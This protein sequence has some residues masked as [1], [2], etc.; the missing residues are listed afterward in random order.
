MGEGGRARACAKTADESGPTEEQG[1]KGE[2]STNR[3]YDAP[4]AALS[5]AEVE[6]LK[7]LLGRLAEVLAP[8]EQSG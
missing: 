6:A 1:E 5:E 4:W 8:E 7:H 3:L 2:D